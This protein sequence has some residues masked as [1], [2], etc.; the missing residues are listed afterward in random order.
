MFT[1]LPVFSQSLERTL[2]STSLPPESQNEKAELPRTFRNLVLGMSLEELKDILIRDQ[3]FSYRGDRDVSFLPIQEQTLI[4]TTGLSFIRRAFFQLEE[5]KLFIM[6][7]ELDPRLVDHYSV[8]TQFVEKYGEPN[9][10]NP[11]QAVWENNLSR[12][13]IERPLTVKYIDKIVFDELI[14]QSNTKE[15]SEME[16]R[17]DF[18][19]DF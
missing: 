5:D 3:L 7:F 6:S 10:L 8:F 11:R 12:I 14:E 1:H 13:S 4:E 17:K 19:N 9:S 18:L 16:L 2:D 15:A